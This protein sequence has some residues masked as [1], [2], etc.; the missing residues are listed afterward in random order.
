MWLLLRIRA[1]EGQLEFHIHMMLKL[2]VV[3][4]WRKVFLQIISGYCICHSISITFSNQTCYVVLQS[5]V[6]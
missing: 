4:V 1:N 2:K 5:F 3:N 6:N